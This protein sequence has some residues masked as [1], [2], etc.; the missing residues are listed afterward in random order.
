M[1][2]HW[3]WYDA[4]DVEMPCRDED[5]IEELEKQLA[6]SARERSEMALQRNPL[7]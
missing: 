5:K 2:S 7:L 4:D 3:S 6:Q 1:S